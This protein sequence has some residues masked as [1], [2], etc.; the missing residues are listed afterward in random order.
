MVGKGYHSLLY[1]CPFHS[2]YLLSLSPNSSLLSTNYL[3]LTHFLSTLA[4]LFST[5]LLTTRCS[6]C[7]G[8][9]RA[10][11]LSLLLCQN[12][13]FDPFSIYFGPIILYFSLLFHNIRIQ[14]FTLVN[15]L[16]L[17][18]NFLVP[19]MGF[20]EFDYHFSTLVQK[21]TFDQFSIYYGPII[22]YFSL[23]FHNIKMK[24]STLVNSF[25][26]M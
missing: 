4:L 8:L 12:P 23:P 24:F 20:I 18:H 19:S 14:F 9:I 21:P 3:F 13:T 5:F 11:C 15:S 16:L 2:T 22:L 25:L 6:R 1:S 26:L 10:H 17:L 7:T